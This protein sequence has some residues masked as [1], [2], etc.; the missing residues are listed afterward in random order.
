MDV[1]SI[2]VCL[3]AR[4]QTSRCLNQHRDLKVEWIHVMRPTLDLIMFIYRARETLMERYKTVPMALVLQAILRENLFLEVECSI[5]LNWINLILL[6]DLFP[7]LET[8]KE[9]CMELPCV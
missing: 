6:G 7:G 5:G 8:V 3:C 9:V 2:Y 1:F 4:C